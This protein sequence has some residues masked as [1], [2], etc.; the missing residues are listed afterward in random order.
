MGGR[1]MKEEDKEHV[2]SMIQAGRYHA[3][4]AKIVSEERIM[5]PSDLVKLLSSYAK[6]TQEHFVVVT[7][8]GAHNV[9]RMRVITKGLVNKT[10]V[11]PREVFRSAIKDNAVAVILSHNHPSGSMEPSKED[12]EITK[13]IKE[14]GD[15]IGIQVLD[16]VIVSKFGSYSFVEHGLFA[17]FIGN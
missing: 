5:M 9:I 8:D 15:I 7:L 11:H 2:I 12:I 17:P 10:M 16:H 13:R 14:A 6:R 3:A 1:S 4:I